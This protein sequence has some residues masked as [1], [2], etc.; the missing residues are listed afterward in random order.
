MTRFVVGSDVSPLIALDL[1]VWLFPFH[2]VQGG[3]STGNYGV[4]KR[5]LPYI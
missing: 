2:G 4:L 5:I 3:G 1:C